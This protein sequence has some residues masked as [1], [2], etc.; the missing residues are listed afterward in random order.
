MKI[1]V[2]GATGF[3]GR[4]V[5]ARLGADHEVIAMP[6]REGMTIEGAASVVVGDVLKP[7]TLAAA[8][9]GVEVLVHSAG[10]VSH[11]PD[12][13][14]A[15]WK[16]HVQGTEN[17]LDAARAAGIP[18]VVYLSTSGTIAVGT[19]ETERDEHAESPLMLIRTWSYYLSLIHI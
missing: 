4:H 9:D 19:D 1:L 12:D 8:M 18:R 14:E 6:R 15:C 11:H 3:L 17:A 5:V 2:T 7:D 13:A 16:V 10:L